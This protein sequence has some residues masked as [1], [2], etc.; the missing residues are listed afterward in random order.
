MITRLVPTASGIGRPPSRASAGTMRKP[1][2]TP[3]RPV[4]SPTAAPCAASSHQAGRGAAPTAWGRPRN[5][6]P[7]ASSITS[8]KSSSWSDPLT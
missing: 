5:M 6:N 2:P 3:T 7:A 4:T 1:P 8:A